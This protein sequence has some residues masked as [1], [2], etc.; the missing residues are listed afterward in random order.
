MPA[1]GPKFRSGL[2]TLRTPD[3]RQ[4]ELH[5]E[6]PIACGLLLVRQLAQQSYLLF[7]EDDFERAAGAKVLVEGGLATV[8]STE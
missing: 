8:L 3:S 2:R 6:F 5:R 4:A 7:S 1:R